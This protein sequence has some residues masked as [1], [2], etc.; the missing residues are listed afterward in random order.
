MNIRI[1][2]YI[3]ASFQKYSDNEKKGAT[4][5]HLSN[6]YMWFSSPC[7]LYC[8]FSSACSLRETGGDE[9]MPLTETSRAF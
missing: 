6:L 1:A 9:W 5:G 3:I 8:Q 4:Q 2:S 7:L